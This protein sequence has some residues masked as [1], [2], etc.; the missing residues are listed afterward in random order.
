[1][2]TYDTQ[3]ESCHESG[4]LRLSFSDYDLVKSGASLLRCNK[5]DGVCQIQFDPSNVQFVLK[6][7]MLSGGW[8]SKALKENKYRAA[9]RQVMARREKDHVF[10]PKLQPN[11]KGME[12]GTWKDAQEAARA[13]VTS[14]YGSKKIGDAAAKTYEPLVTKDK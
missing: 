13:E 6:D 11:Y 8:T 2:P 12:T 7:G 5:C 3:C 4:A 1:M 10:T 9:H 14:D